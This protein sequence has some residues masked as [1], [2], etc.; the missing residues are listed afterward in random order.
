MIQSNPNPRTWERYE[1]Y[2]S[3]VLGFHGCD[4]SVGEAVLNGEIPHLEFSR[5]DYDW[6]GEGVYFWESS[7]ARALDFARERAQGGRNSRGTIYEPFI[8]GVVINLGHCFITTEMGALTRLANA[9]QSLVKYTQAQNIP[10]PTNGQT[11]RARRL[12]CATFNLMHLLIEESG[13]TPYDSVR[14]AFWEGGALYPNAG[15]QSADH[16]QICAANLDCVLGYFR[17]L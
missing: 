16:T 5:N 12:D 3:F 4:R 2:S 15:F 9:Y 11:L 13:Q 6:L 14:A 7:P 17:P 8:V 1:V 10:L